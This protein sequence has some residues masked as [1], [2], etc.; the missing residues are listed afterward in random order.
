MSRTTVV[1][2]VL[3]AQR[4]SETDPAKNVVFLTIT[5]P[6]VPPEN[7]KLDITSTRITFTGQSR[8]Y[9]YHLDM[10]LYGEIDTEASTHKHSPR[11]IEFVLRK[12][13]AKKEFW[14][15]LV[16]AQLKNVRTDFDKWVDEDEQE[17]EEVE[18]P[19]EDAGGFGGID[20]SK[21]GGD[22]GN[23]GN[24]GN[25][26]GGDFSGLAGEHPGEGSDDDEMPE[27]EAAGNIEEETKTEAVAGSGIEE[28]S[29]KQ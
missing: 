10:E 20:F 11:G 12:K 21:M 29:D 24:L 1:P 19:G 8:S 9:D 6:D 27:L 5:A 26:G 7:V 4:S 18:V 15:R 3:W 25:L 2:E 28:I 16:K 17:E 14:P 23:L 13:E 22:F